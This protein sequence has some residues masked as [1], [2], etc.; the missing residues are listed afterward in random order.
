M[1]A[2]GPL[3]ALAAR[4]TVPAKSGI[5]L[6]KSDMVV[7]ARLTEGS[8]RINERRRM[9][10]DVLKSP[11]SIGELTKT[12][13]RLLDFCAIHVERYDALSTAF[14]RLGPHVDGWRVACERTMELLREIKAELEDERA[15]APG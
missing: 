8:L 5:Y 2:R 12:V 6:S 1:I 4:L 13:D 9:L 7:L 10:S 14:P 3:D 15:R 11:D